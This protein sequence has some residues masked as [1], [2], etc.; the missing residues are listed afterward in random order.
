[1]FYALFRIALENVRN[2]DAGLD[3]LPMGL[4]M[5]IAL[6]I[7]MLLI[8]AWLTWRALSR[9]PLVAASAPEAA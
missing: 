5:G 8:G 7:P 2:P 1:M 4:T 6:S 9:P 3:R